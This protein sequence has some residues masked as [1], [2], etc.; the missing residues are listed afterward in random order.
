MT[1]D[2]VGIATLVLVIVTGVGVYLAWGQLRQA[3]TIAR[4]DLLVK[5]HEQFCSGE[6]YQNV[7]RKIEN[8][9][10]SIDR[11]H[12]TDDIS[13]LDM[14]L[15]FFEIVKHSID[16]GVVNIRRAQRLFCYYIL[17]ARYCAPINKYISDTSD[18][19]IDFRDLAEQMIPFEQERLRKT[20]E[21]VIN[22]YTSNG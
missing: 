12:L 16:E 13:N 18:Y 22:Y 19:W 7:I 9:E 11:T 5:L 1:Y 21:E 6:R 2:L 20:R 14:Y 10:L 8:K 3:R 4:A 17:K 15:G